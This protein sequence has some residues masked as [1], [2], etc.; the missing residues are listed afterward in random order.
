MAVNQQT[1]ARFEGLNPIFRVQDLSQSV[2]YYVNVLGFKVD[3]H[4]TGI[5][6]SVSRDRCA[7][8]LVE[9]DQGHPGGWVWI[10]VSDVE[11]LLQEYE[12]KGARIRHPPTNYS[13]AYEMQVEDPDGNVLRFGS[14]PKKGQPIGEWFDMHGRKWAPVPGGGWMLEEDEG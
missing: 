6:T 7:I 9:G 12:S 2:D 13:W 3:F 8:F 11:L 4:A 10:G 1:K 5:I 14:E